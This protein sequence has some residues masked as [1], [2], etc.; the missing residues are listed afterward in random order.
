MRYSFIAELAAPGRKVPVRACDVEASPVFLVPSIGEYPVYDEAAYEAMIKDERRM[1]AYAEAV[2]RHAPGRTVL[3][4][5]TG[6][7]AVW[8][9]AAARA[10]ARRVWAVEVIPQS[11]R[12]AR[13]TIEEAGFADR[14]TV[15]EGLS[16][17][18]ELPEPVDMC[19]SEIIGTLGGSEG[20]GA[21]L[22]DARE[23]LVKPGGVFI[24]H[25]S[26]TTAVALDLGSAGRGEPLGFPPFVFRYVEEV[27]ASVGRPFDL[28]VVLEG[29]QDNPK[30]RERAYLS[31]PVELEPLEF[32][33]DLNPEGVDG[34]ELTFTRAGTFSGLALGM[35]LWVAEDDEPIDSLVQPSSWTPV[36]APLSVE[37]LPVRPGDRFEFDF[38]TTLSDDGVH[39]DYAL[40]G[41]LYRPG[42]P[43]APLS[44]GSTHHGDGFRATPF[45][46]SLFPGPGGP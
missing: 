39:P 8:A 12:I 17:E 19:V 41:E 36:Y 30:V 46:R 45:Y 14:I 35:R 9:L 32:N 3:D 5:G 38:T 20:A 28:R 4:I 42:G 22:R 7:D 44:W 37:G 1:G 13:K 16:T 29:L 6:K 24:P 18:I 26:A 11:A 23:R 15:V 27:F 2:R 40:A 43:A 34:A 10:G 21:V 31:G 33:G 25:R